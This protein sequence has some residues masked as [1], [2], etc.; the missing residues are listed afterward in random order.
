MLAGSEPVLQHDA[1]RDASGVRRLD[2]R[3]RPFERDLQRLFQ[4]HVLAGRGC[5]LRQLQMRVRRRQHHHRVDAAVGEDRIDV[6]GDGKTPTRGESGAPRFG[7]AVGGR[8][9]DAV[10]KVEQALRMR[11]DGHAEPDDGDALPCQA[12]ALRYCLLSERQAAAAAP[13][14]AQG[15]R[16][17]ATSATSAVR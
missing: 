7:R 12:F 8:D 13:L 15:S 11:G 4:K 14:L 10:G 16:C 5:A 17:A 3:L 1:E 2:Q 6:G 9:L